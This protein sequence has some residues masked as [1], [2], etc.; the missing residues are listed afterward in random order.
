[1]G[2]DDGNR[3]S[4]QGMN[5]LYRFALAT[6][7]ATVALIILGSLAR[8]HPAGTGCGNDWPRCN[9]SWL[10]ALAREPLV[11]YAHRGVALAVVAL[12]VGTVVAS[13]TTTCTVRRHRLLATAALLA[14]VVQ[15]AIGGFAARWG[16]PPGIASAHLIAAMLF[17]ACAIATLAA[18]AA[19]RGA[20]RWLAALGR[21][22]SP[23]ADRLFALVASGAAAIVLFLVI[24]GA[25]TSATGAFACAAWPLCGDDGA[26]T[27]VAAVHLGYRATALLGT[28]AAGSTALLA[29]RRGA[30]PVARRLAT[31]AVAL[32]VVQ[33]GLNALATVLGD[34]VWMSAPHLLVATL[35]WVVML[36]VALAA[37]GLRP[38]PARR[39]ALAA[40]KAGD[41]SGSGDAGVAP[42][43]VAVWP[44]GRLSSM[45]AAAY[46]ELG[47]DLTLPALMRAR[48]VVADYVALTKPG[49]LTLLL[50]TTLCAMLMAARGLPPFTLVAFT[51]LGGLLAAG[52]ANVLNC[53]LDR[54]IDGQ[55]AR[56][57]HRA[58]V[59]GRVSP[60]AALAFG[61]T[62]T[63]A[64][65]LV[66]GSLVN[67]PAALLALAGNLFYVFVYTR[68]LKRA[69]PYNIVIGGAAGAVPPLV[70]WAAVSGDLSPLALGL[71]AIVFAWTPPHFWALALLKQ[72][73]Y[74][75]AAVPMLPVVRGEAE[76]RLQIVLYTVVLCLVCLA[77][78][79]L[80]L[81]GIYLAAAL[82]L[83]GI[84]LWLALRL[85]TR[86]SKRLARQMFFYSLWYLAVLFAA[87]VVDRIVIS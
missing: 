53:Y 41:A 46:P 37:W 1:M 33:S 66:L 48:T 3:Q 62:L 30:A 81:G 57:R 52:G 56:T 35:L 54:D 78:A 58:I 27:S 11:E 7:L 64:S 4:A 5:R 26:A 21:A 34:P 79:P 17:L 39:L 59:A 76:T 10:P 40:D 82:A 63:V 32:V 86:P 71:F 55:M 42:T 72:G 61:V 28:L 87:A 51:M 18:A 83:N 45:A 65:V 13:F 15:S 50:T 20:P 8:L 16:A 77:L 19:L 70:G 12:T 31:A 38:V 9:G 68:W 25:S 67:W 22:P 49:I 74:T 69:T 75:R 44:S 43:R 85:Y 23:A 14:I 73:E 84:F 60:D 2:G 6:V 47:W 24:F 29:W 80:G 36:G